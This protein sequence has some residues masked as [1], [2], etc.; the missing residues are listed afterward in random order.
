M[1]GHKVFIEMNFIIKTHYIIHFVLIT[2][3]VRRIF[4]IFFVVCRFVSGLRQHKMLHVTFR[5][6][7]STSPTII[8]HHQSIIYSSKPPFRKVYVYLFKSMCIRTESDTTS[9]IIISYRKAFA[10]TFMCVRCTLYVYI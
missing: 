7:T 2:E 1:S 8:H 4:A 9:L 5:S 6:R 10:Y 3:N